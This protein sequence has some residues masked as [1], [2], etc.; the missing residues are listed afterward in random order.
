MG[1]AEVVG[2]V[3]TDSYEYEESKSVADGKFVGLACDEDNQPDLSEERVNAWIDQIMARACP[4]KCGAIACRLLGH[5]AEKRPEPRCQHTTWKRRGKRRGPQMLAKRMPRAPSPSMSGDS[6]V[7]CVRREIP[8]RVRRT[9]IAGGGAL[10]ESTC[11][12]T[13]IS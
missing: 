4:S 12:E 7:R 2:S 11:N 8:R 13:V 1:G 9:A 5:H 10:Q 6:A 3:A